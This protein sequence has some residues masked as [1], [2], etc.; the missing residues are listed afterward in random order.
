MPHLLAANLAATDSPSLRWMAC[1]A[2]G[3][4]IAHGDARTAHYLA[5]DLR[6]QWRDRLGD[7]HKHVRGVAHYLAWALQEMGRYAEARDLDQDTLARD[8]RILGEDHV[9]TLSSANG[10]AIALRALG[11]RMMIPEAVINTQ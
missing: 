8:R 11:G 9:M 3:Y 4:L 2:C 1:N 7:D 10:L 5:S 6:Q